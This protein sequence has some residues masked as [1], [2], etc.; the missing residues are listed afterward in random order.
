MVSSQHFSK[1]VC[2]SFARLLSRSETS[3]AASKRQFKPA[4]VLFTMALAILI[5]SSLT[6][7]N[8]VYKESTRSELS[9]F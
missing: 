9:S 5:S 6:S 1:D 7:L 4:P 8:L 2:G 3:F